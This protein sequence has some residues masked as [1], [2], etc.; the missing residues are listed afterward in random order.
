MVLIRSMNLWIVMD[1]DDLK[2]LEKEKNVCSCFLINQFDMTE[3]LFILS[4]KNCI[5]IEIKS[6][7][8]IKNTFFVCLSKKIILP[9]SN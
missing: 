8:S 6:A 5:K 1:C 9:H 2:G 7:L 3:K 4:V